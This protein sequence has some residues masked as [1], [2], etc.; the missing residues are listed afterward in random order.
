M[1]P[2]YMRPH[3]QGK[4]ARPG[5]RPGTICQ[6]LFPGCWVGMVIA[7]VVT[8]VACSASVNDDLVGTPTPNPVRSPVVGASSAAMAPALATPLG[9]VWGALDRGDLPAAAD[10][11]ATGVVLGPV[12]PDALAARAQVRFRSGDLDG[13]RADLDRAVARVPGRADLLMQR[14]RV[15]VAQGEMDA[16]QTDDAAAIAGDP[17][18]VGAF[19]HRSM[20]RTLMAQGVPAT[21]QAALDDANRALALDP[22]SWSARI[23]RA[24][25]YQAR[26]AFRGDPADI[27]HALAELEKL[28]SGPGGPTAALIRAQLLAIRGDLA[29]ARRERDQAIDGIP[30]P[31]PGA[32]A[33]AELAVT[34]AIVAL[35]NRDWEQT[36]ARAEEALAVDPE[37]WDAR[38]L[39]A[40]SLLGAGNTG[41]ALTVINLTRDRW[42]ENGVGWYLRGL[43]L[44]QQGD[45]SGARMALERA[46][47]LLV[48]SP[49]YLARIA[50]AD[51]GLP[52][53]H[54]GTPGINPSV[55][56]LIW[57]RR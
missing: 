3:E 52:S 47:S 13:A 55:T 19:I 11:A 42:S 44:I 23:A 49:V 54:H 45:D 41:A 4:A 46:R 33:V 20:V 10:A 16:A 56:A 1:V 37:R 31:G 43:A 50:Q 21:Y 14:A 39:L 18:L 15:E 9:R 22:E 57:G 7:V 28:R 38:M 24:R 51:R 8:M 35:E 2:R 12:D 27:D 29:S 30:M 40:Q 32:P 53:D 17:G 36:A 34:D 26:A 6:G 5:H 48:A 25:V